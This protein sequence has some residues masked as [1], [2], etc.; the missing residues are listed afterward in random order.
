M[1]TVGGFHLVV[2]VGGGMWIENPE[3]VKGSLKP[4][5]PKSTCHNVKSSA[6]LRVGG[7]IGECFA[8]LGLKVGFN[9]HIM[10]HFTQ[11]GGNY[12]TDLVV[13]NSGKAP[14]GK[15]KICSMS[16]LL[17]QAQVVGA[18]RGGQP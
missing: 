15:D 18:R 4:S 12:V 10:A 16:K 13:P 5:T 11:Q 17:P 14:I 2:L 8:F 7:G 9:S 1:A 3:V 6:I